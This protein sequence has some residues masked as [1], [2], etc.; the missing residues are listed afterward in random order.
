MYWKAIYINISVA[1][2]NEGKRPLGIQ[3]CRCDDSV[4]KLIK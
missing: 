4:K 2:K 3:K 1:K